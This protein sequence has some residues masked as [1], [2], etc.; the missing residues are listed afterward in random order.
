MTE[1][2]AVLDLRGEVC[3]LPELRV[4]KFLRGNAAR[5]PFAVLLDHRPTLESIQALAARSGFRC[6]VTM[7]KGV[8]RARF[9]HGGGSAP[10]A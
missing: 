9:I 8:L 7:E 5:R 1:S 6:D 4:E 3:A 2:E 10:E